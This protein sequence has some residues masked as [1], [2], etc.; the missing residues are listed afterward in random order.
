MAYSV[1]SCQQLSFN[2]KIEYLEAVKKGD[3]PGV[4]A[5]KTLKEDYASQ[6]GD[7]AILDYLVSV[8]KRCW[9]QNT[10]SRPNMVVI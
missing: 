9:Q 10:D 4:E 6:E 2:L 7:L 1:A 3:R 8:M 5:I